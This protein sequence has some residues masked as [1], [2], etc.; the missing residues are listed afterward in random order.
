[1]PSSGF[2]NATPFIQVDT[3]PF[4]RT[5]TEIYLF[6]CTVISGEFPARRLPGNRLRRETERKFRGQEGEAKMPAGVVP[7]WRD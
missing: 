2:P 6:V 1:L 4:Y 3:I 5:L 7:P